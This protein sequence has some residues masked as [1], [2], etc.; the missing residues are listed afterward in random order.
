MVS[1]HSLAHKDN[2]PHEAPRRKLLKT[3]EDGKGQ[4]HTR[5][6]AHGHSSLPMLKWR[7]DSLSLSGCCPTLRFLQGFNNSLPE[8]QSLGSL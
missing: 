7:Q 2:A 5:A 6:V 3:E 4:V 8:F 1:L